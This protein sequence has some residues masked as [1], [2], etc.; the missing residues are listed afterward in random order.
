MNFES[1]E[2][3]KIIT[4][5]QFITKWILCSKCYLNELYLNVTMIKP[6]IR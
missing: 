1:C 5:N 4:T 3:N 2:N 6:L